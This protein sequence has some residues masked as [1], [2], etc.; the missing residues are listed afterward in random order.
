[1]STVIALADVL[2]MGLFLGAGLVSAMLNRLGGGRTRLWALTSGAFIILAAER[3]LNVLE[4]AI[5]GAFAWLDV[6]QGYVSALAYLVLLAAVF[7][8]ALILRHAAPG[9]SA[10]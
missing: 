2:A 6:F 5:P 7:D 3:T 8:F 4:W 10:G 9:D 1:M